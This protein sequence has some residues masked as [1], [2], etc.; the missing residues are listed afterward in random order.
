MRQ[1]VRSVVRIASAAFVFVL[2]A[3][4]GASAQT[5]STPDWVAAFENGLRPA[6]RVEGE[7][8]QQWSIEEGLQRHNVPGVS[9]AIIRNGSLVWARGYGFSNKETGEKVNAETVFS[10]GSIS[11]LGAAA[12]TLRLVAAGEIDLNRDVNRYLKSW[13]VPESE[14][15]RRA[16]VTLRGILSHTAGL[17]VSGFDDYWPGET[18]PTIVQTLNGAPPAKNEAVRAIYVPGTETRYSGGGTTV[19]ELLISDVTGK[20][21]EQAAEDLVF[22]PLGMARSTYA[23]P[24]PKEHGNIAWAYDENG[25]RSAEPRGWHAFPEKAASGLWTT[26]TDQSKFLFAL[27]ESYHGADDAFLPQSVAADMMTEVGVSAFGLGPVMHGDGDM[28]RLTHSG[29]NFAYRAWFEGHLATGDGLLVFTNG[30]NGG[31]LYAEIRRAV[32]DALDWPFYRERILPKDV[33]QLEKLN[34][35]VGRYAINRPMSPSDFR[36]AYSETPDFDVVKKGDGLHMRVAETDENEEAD[37]Y[38]IPLR[39]VAPMAFVTDGDYWGSDGGLYLSFVRTKKGEI[40]GAVL[41]MG[42]Y[43]SMAE[44]R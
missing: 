15:T 14:F 18:L 34:A 20:T 40:T 41:K 7:T 38:T 44:K 39:Q 16:P 29:A 13:N 42:D 27:M 26:P 10:V 17:S 31:A 3:A 5:A 11:K 19:Q 23:N 43:S 28:R 9:I 21:F 32:A 25:A 37:A 6:M 2:T 33:P 22:Q 35:F 36:G 24:L 12:T 1:T 4:F 30:F 8:P